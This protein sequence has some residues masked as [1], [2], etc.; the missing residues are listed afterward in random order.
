MLSNTHPLFFIVLYFFLPLGVIQAG[1]HTRKPGNHKPSHMAYYC[2]CSARQ[3][4]NRAAQLAEE[5]KTKNRDLVGE[6]SPRRCCRCSLPSAAGWPKSYECS[7]SASGR[8]RRDE[9]YIPNGERKRKKKG[10]ADPAAAPLLTLNQTKIS[11][12]TI[13]NTV[14]LSFSQL[15]DN[16][17]DS[18]L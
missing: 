3:Y 8:S 16:A 7:R 1:R 5:K 14:I 15:I 18:D 2:I 9:R 12:L 11:L 10:A 17:T 4:N 6:R 13:H